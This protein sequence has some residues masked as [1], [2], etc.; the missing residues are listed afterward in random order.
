MEK[1]NAATHS[2]ISTQPHTHTPP[3]KLKPND[4]KRVNCLQLSLTKPQ[5]GESSPFSK[6]QDLPRNSLVPPFF[7]PMDLFLR[8]SSGLVQQCEPSRVVMSPSSDWP[9]YEGVFIVSDVAGT[10]L[11]TPISWFQASKTVELGVGRLSLVGLKPE[12][13]FLY[14]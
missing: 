3:L 14:V 7:I 1:Q 6:G 9:T 8:T 2:H 13:D 12:I 4:P 10:P 11:Q 5:S